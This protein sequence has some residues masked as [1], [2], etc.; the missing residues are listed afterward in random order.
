MGASR[1][2][3]DF[4]GL[5]GDLLCLSHGELCED[6]LGNKVILRAGMQVTV[7]QEDLDHN[8]NRDDLLA[9]GTVIPS[10]DWLACRGSVW[11][12]QIDERGVRHESDEPK[13]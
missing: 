4:N 12:L 3:A 5:A 1:L 7:F 11:A 8:N 10:P 13:P 2:L 6:E 9:S